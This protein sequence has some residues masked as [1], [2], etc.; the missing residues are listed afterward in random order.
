MY[1]HR[2]KRESDHHIWIDKG[3]GYE[4]KIPKKNYCIGS[5]YHFTHYYEETPEVK[6]IFLTDFRR[7]KYLYYCEKIKSITDEAFMEQ[8]I[9]LSKKQ[10]DNGKQEG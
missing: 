10:I 9:Q 8:I 7:R 3:N 2:V 6:A 5:G 1:R 4:L